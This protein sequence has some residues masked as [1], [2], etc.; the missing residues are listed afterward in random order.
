MKERYI[1]KLI[2]KQKYKK[3]YYLLYRLIK[4]KYIWVYR[5]LGDCYR[6]GYYVEVN[7]KVALKYYFEGC[8]KNDTDAYL[9]LAE[10]YLYGL[11]TKIDVELAYDYIKLSYDMNNKKACFYMGYLIDFGFKEEDALKYYLEG[12]DEPICMFALYNY[13]K[14]H[15]NIDLALKYLSKACTLNY[16]KALM[17]MGDLYNDGDI[18]SLDYKKAFFFYKKASKYNMAKACY[19]MAECFY[20]ALGVKGSY[21]KA[22]K[23]YKKCDKMEYIEATNKVADCLYF[24]K[25]TKRDLVLAY[26]N[27]LKASLKCENLEEKGYAYFCLGKMNYYGEGVGKDYNLAYQNLISSLE[28]FDFPSSHLLIGKCYVHGYGCDVDLKKGYEHLKRAEL[29]GVFDFEENLLNELCVDLDG[30]VSLKN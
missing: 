25:G 13:Y 24:S 5:Y 9:K 17:Q 22:F 30:R 1:E 3:A 29:F 23:Y 12:E 27:Y 11:G 6:Y 20:Y 4:K 19:M 10:M 14:K 18:V 2:L 7:Y 28:C 26:H 15:D 21:K 16:P 8:K